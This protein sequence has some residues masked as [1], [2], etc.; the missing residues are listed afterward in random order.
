MTFVDETKL[1]VEAGDGGRGCIAF[2]REKFVPRGGPSGGDGGTGGSIWLV[3]DEGVSTLLKFKYKPLHR[4]PRGN[5]GEGSNKTGAN[6]ADFVLTVPVGTVVRDLESDTVVADLAQAGERYCL[7]KGGHG[8]RGNAR[9]A[10]ATRQAPRF[11]TPPQDGEKGKFQLTLKLLASVGL[12]GLPNAGKSSLLSRI[13]AARPKVAD[14]PFTTLTPQ[15]G[16]VA[17]GDEQTFVVADIPGLIEGAHE[18]HGLGDRFLRHVERTR[19]LVHLIDVADSETD[20]LESFRV[21][22]RELSLAPGGLADKPFLVAFNKMDAVADRE[23]VDAAVASLEAE[24]IDTELMSVATGL[25]VDR[26]VNWLAVR[27]AK[28]VEVEA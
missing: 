16:V 5:H 2:R 17:V 26:V 19:L 9:F 25:G 7:A 13:S 14:Y 20:P 27:L 11:A 18:G 22:R 3:A 1:E 23:V 15:L 4:A 21:V 12:V 28:G 10:T 8:G 24:G 6:A